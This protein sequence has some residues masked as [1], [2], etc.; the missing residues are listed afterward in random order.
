MYIPSHDFNI[1]TIQCGGSPIV[2]FDLIS[3]SIPVCPLLHIPFS[4]FHVGVTR[5][6]SAAEC[7]DCAAALHSAFFLI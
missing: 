6:G 2:T 1:L 3:L 7:H 4:V 5:L